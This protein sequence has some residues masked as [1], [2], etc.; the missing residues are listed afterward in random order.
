MQGEVKFSW[1]M[2]FKGYIMVLTLRIKIGLYDQK[3]R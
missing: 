2:F 3:N 1:L